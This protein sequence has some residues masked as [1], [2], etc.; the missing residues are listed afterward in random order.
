MREFSIST[1]LRQSL[2]VDLLQLLLKIMRDR[3]VNIGLPT[4]LTVA[5]NAITIPAN[6]GSSFTVDANAASTNLTT[7]N[8]GLQGDMLFFNTVNNA[9]AIVFKH[10]GGNIICSGSVD[11]TLSDTNDTIMAL[12][13]GTNWRCVFW[14]YG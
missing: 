10:S 4:A 3:R 11:L 5:S 13:D 2:S 9:H 14:D 6:T 12:F 8:G 7:I 1:I